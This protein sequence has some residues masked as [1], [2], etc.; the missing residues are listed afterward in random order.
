MKEIL[1]WTTQNMFTQNYL[2]FECE[3]WEDL[4][5]D[6]KKVQKHMSELADILSDKMEKKIL[7]PP[8]IIVIART[9]LTNLM[10]MYNETMYSGGK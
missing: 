5:I 2:Q 4:D 10:T 6:I 7:T 9:L 1:D 3:L 8:E